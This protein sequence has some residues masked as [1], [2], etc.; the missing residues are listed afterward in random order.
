VGKPSIF[1]K[2]YEKKMKNRRRNSIII[3]LAILLVISA[4]IIKVIYNP[5]DYGNIKGN[6][7]A[8]IDS[9]NNSNT[10]QIEVKKEGKS[11]DEE[12]INNEIVKEEPEKPLE[13]FVDITLDSGTIVKAI[14]V[15]DN[16]GEEIFKTLDTTEKGVSFSISPS[17]KQMIVT[18][19]NSVITL[20]NVDGTTKIIS[21]DEYISTNGGIF[22]KEAAMQARPQYLWNANPKFISDEKIIFVT[23]RPYFGKTANKQYLWITDI[24]TGVDSVLWE[25]AGE[26]IEI[27]E[28]EEKGIKITIDGNSYYIDVYGNYVQ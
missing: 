9:D 5:I 10:K 23:N 26:N 28:K 18:D 6:I 25:L 22:T 21:K 24:Q 14:Y 7:Q 15:D 20:Y 16:N 17:S 3:S 19:T 12:I 11:L 8:W 4:L 13:K 2:E 27:G 1:S